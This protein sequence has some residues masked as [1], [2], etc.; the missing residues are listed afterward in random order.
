M[1]VSKPGESRRVERRNLKSNSQTEILDD[2]KQ[3]TVPPYNPN[4]DMQYGCSRK[5]GHKTGGCYWNPPEFCE[6]RILPYNGERWVQACQCH[7]CY[8]YKSKTCPASKLP[9][10]QYINGSPIY[11]EPGNRKP[12]RVERPT[13][14]RTRSDIPNESNRPKRVSTT[15]EPPRRRRIS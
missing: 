7:V 13:T 9:R 15:Q 1:R 5:T 14:G 10:I 3:P 4:Y 6:N 2:K 11:D 12:K 8:R